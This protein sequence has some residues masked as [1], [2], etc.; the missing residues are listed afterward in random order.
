MQTD[1][2]HHYHKEEHAVERDQA[3]ETRVEAER[4]SV[5]SDGLRRACDRRHDSLKGDKDLAD[6]GK[7]EHDDV[8]HEPTF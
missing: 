4:G 7:E 1:R 8:K 5:G 2:D 3:C 6:D